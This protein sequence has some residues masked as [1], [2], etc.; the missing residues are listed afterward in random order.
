[1]NE[2]QYFFQ[3]ENFLTGLTVR[4]Y[5]VLVGDGICTDV[6]ITDDTIACKPPASEP[7]S[8]AE[9]KPRVQVTQTMN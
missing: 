3:G 1:M 2:C 4:M 5:K 7:G 9:S 6:F 8:G